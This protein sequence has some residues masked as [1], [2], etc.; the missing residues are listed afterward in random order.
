MSQINLSVEDFESF[1]RSLSIMREYCE[2]CDIKSGIVRQRAKD[3]SAIFEMDLTSIIT[4]IDLP[5]DLL[6]EQLD[7]LKSFLTYEVA[8]ETSNEDF[9]FSDNYSKL[10]V[11]SPD[12][13]YINTRFMTS[14]DLHNIFSIEEDGL[15]L[16]YRLPKVVTD[17]MKEVT[18]VFNV[19]S[20]RVDFEGETVKISAKNDGNTRHQ[21]FI[22]GIT[23]EKILEGY[24][25]LFI[26]PFVIDH[27][28]DMLFQ[29]YQEGDSNVIIN[30]FSTSIADIDVVVYSRSTLRT[31]EDD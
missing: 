11:R 20:M 12:P 17:R 2:G 13:E 25:E 3:A 26:T 16:S 30:K 24:S 31:S 23:T 15:L 19:S 7:L 28:G 6:K 10:K 27:D 9:I 1:H 8:I 18:K 22:G 5:I 14:E 4:D 21:D 29:M